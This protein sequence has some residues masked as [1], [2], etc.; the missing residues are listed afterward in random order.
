VYH[1]SGTIK[2]EELDLKGGDLEFDLYVGSQDLLPRKVTMAGKLDLGTGGAGGA[3]VPLSGPADF[4]LAMTFSNFGV[5]VQIT[6]PP[7]F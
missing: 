5:P 7:G 4:V 2:A 1:Y 6:P 3:P